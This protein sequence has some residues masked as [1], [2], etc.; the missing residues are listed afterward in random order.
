MEAINT[1]LLISLVEERPELWDKT[2][3][4]YKDRDLKDAAW[5]DICTILIEG[6]EEMEQTQRQEFGKLVLRKWTQTRDSWMKAMKKRKNQRSSAKRSRPYIYHE[7]MSFL[8]KII[9]LSDSVDGD[10][11]TSVDFTDEE[12]VVEEDAVAQK[13]TRMPIRNDM[14]AKILKFM[15][16]QMNGPK[17][18]ENRHNAFFKSILP[19]LL[20]LDDDQTL[21]FQAGVINLLQNIK[22]QSLT[23][24]N[25]PPSLRSNECWN[26]Q[27]GLSNAHFPQQV[28][29]PATP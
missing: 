25:P 10:A 16:H 12:G 21:Q 15:E 29:H 28:K 19:T 1:E 14:D 27:D 13:R 6:F 17:E 5:R 11:S 7:E 4:V 8:K 23:F 26:D 9:N 20:L 18:Q 22:S 3:D 2:L 24:V